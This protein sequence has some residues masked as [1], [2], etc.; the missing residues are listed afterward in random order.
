MKAPAPSTRRRMTWAVMVACLSLNLISLVTSGTLESDLAGDPDEAAHAVTS[1]MMRD[2]MAG[3]W[4]QSPMP[5]ANAYYADFPKV[6]L[7]HYP[8]GYYLL[9]GLWLLPFASIKSL[10]V[11]QA[12]LSATLAT[13]LYRVASKFVSMPAA[14]L[15]GLLTAAMPFTL[16]QEQ[17]VMSDILLACLCLVAATS[18]GSYMNRPSLRRA[19]GFGALATAAILTKGSAIG[20]CAVPLMAT[21]IN[22]RWLLLAKPSWWLS[23]LPV[24]V[25]AGP[26]MIFSTKITAEGMLHQP[27]GEFFKEAVSYYALALPQTL[28]WI[29]TI[30]SF[31]GLAWLLIGSYKG[32]K[33]ATTAAALCGLVVGILAVMLLVP[34]GTTSRYFM[35]LFAVLVLAATMAT[36]VLCSYL[37]RFRWTALLLLMAGG[38]AVVTQ[39]PDKNVHGFT[40]AVVRSGVPVKSTEA[41]RWLIAS[42]PR[43]EGAV[44][45]AAAFNS[46]HRSPSFL[47]IYRGSKELAT[48]DWL[49]RDYQSP[50]SNE[51]DLLNHLDKLQVNRVFL[52]LSLPKERRQPHELLLEK[53]MH[54]AGNRWKLDF[55][56]IIT[57]QYGESGNLLVYIRVPPVEAIKALD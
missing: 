37:P 6:A 23:A 53:A 2:Y 12:V 9:S 11:L 52:D 3:G 56:Q 19:L 45:A 16:K 48:S 27:I 29:F 51:T 15:A 8:P 30:L 31:G 43:G 49:G 55:E 32:T 44:I 20:L 39:W 46:Q 54:S 25:L 22:R 1:L 13:L 38:F 5:F 33:N 4:Q 10:F 41:T 42:D 40:A 47:R 14:M 35:P 24:V 21:A 18:W 50:F 28:G 17:F 26:W 36:D 7:G 57:R 34:A